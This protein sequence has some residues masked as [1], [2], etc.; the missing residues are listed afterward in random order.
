MVCIKLFY[1]SSDFKDWHALDQAEFF[2]LHIL[3]YKNH[4]S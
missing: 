3:W 4:N 1:I 2:L